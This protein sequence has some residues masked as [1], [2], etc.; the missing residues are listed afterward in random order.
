[1]RKSDYD[2][3]RIQTSTELPTRRSRPIRRRDGAGD[4]PGTRT[5]HPD[6]ESTDARPSE[7]V[8]ERS[9]TTPRK[10][11]LR[12]LGLRLLELAGGDTSRAAPLD[13]RSVVRR[14]AEAYSGEHLDEL[15]GVAR[16]LYLMAHNL[17]RAALA[18]F[19]SVIGEHARG[20]LDEFAELAL[21]A[22]AFCLL[23]L[24]CRR[25]ARAEFERLVREKLRDGRDTESP[26]RIA[27]LVGLLRVLDTPS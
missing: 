21:E 6:P 18:A 20:E 10:P 16:G 15:R 8:R 22:H 5:N 2:S 24:D 7:P 11:E 17:Y 9:P 3:T 27:T 4:E 25:D 19:E 26:T 14:T 13:P 1:M 12:W 23:R